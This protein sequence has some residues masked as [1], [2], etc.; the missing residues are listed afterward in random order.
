M[1]KIILRMSKK[2]YNHIEIVCDLSEKYQ[3]GHADMCHEKFK[4]NTGC[5]EM[6]HL[7]LWPSFWLK[8][9][10]SF[11]ISVQFGTFE[12]KTIFD[13]WNLVL[14]KVS[15]NSGIF[16]LFYPNCQQT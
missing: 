2:F 8:L 4:W 7:Q 11:N 13:E 16:F 3:N 1:G 12:G 5:S 6:H 15:E 9:A 14:K 10:L